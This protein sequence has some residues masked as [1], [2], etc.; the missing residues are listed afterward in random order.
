ME[1]AISITL[2]GL[3][4]NIE[5]D[6]YERLDNYL[7]SIRRYYGGE[8]SKE[9]LADIESSIAEKFNDKIK[10]KKKI[11]TKK[12]VEEV[13]K[14]MGEVEDF[15]NEGEETNKKPSSR[16]SEGQAFHIGKRLYRNPDDVVIAGVCSGIAAYFGIDPVFVRIVMFLLIFAN[17]VGVLAYFIL[18]IVMPE[19]ETNSQKLEMKGE[20][21]NVKKLEESIK[22][23]AQA[24][25]EEGQNAIN[26]IKTQKGVL[27]KIINFPIVIFRAMIVFLRKGI[28]LIWPITRIFFGVIFIITAIA[29]IFGMTVLSGVMLFNMS[30][31]Y[32]VSDL[33][34]E[35]LTSSVMY[36]VGILGIYF[37]VVVPVLFLFI[38]GFTMLRNK[39]TFRVLSSSFLLGLW[40]ISVVAGVVAAGDLTPKVMEKLEQTRELETVSHTYE[41]KDFTKL[42]LSAHMDAVVK[43]G[44]EFSITMEGREKDLDRLE[45]NIEEGQLQITQKPREEEGKFCVF[46]FDQNIKAEIILPDLESFVAIRSVKAEVDSFDSM[47]KVSV[48]E[49]AQVDLSVNGGDLEVFVAGASSRLNIMDSSDTL[50]LSME[51]YSRFYANDL[52]AENIIIDMDSLSR[53]TLKGETANLTAEVSGPAD[54]FAKDLAAQTAKVKVTSHGEAEI[55]AL[56]SLDAIAQEHGRIYYKGNPSLST[57]TAQEG[58][59][60]RLDDY[61]FNDVRIN[62]GDKKI[63]IIFGSD[64]YSPTMSSIRGIELEPSYLDESVRYIW[65]TNFGNLVD[66][67]DDPIYVQSITNDGDSIYWT[68]M[69]D[70]EA[71]LSEEPIY[72]YLRAK[73][74]DGD[75]ISES[76]LKLEEESEGVFRVVD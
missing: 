53:A 19:A 67:W 18:W 68:F 5:E 8:E 11:I 59:V 1:K 12:D 34:L 39:N 71:S 58:K 70:S 32:I 27:Y 26:R 14:V 65:S 9:I 30:S 51:G 31:P 76:E 17:G 44:E 66:S 57:K 33:P 48:G 20:P 45:F 29:S 52:D 16:S 36:Y 35:I 63:E 4:F 6:A 10:G 23:K 50:N 49:T 28:L 24:A 60:E 74:D 38:L 62:N 7:E 22:E 13:I 15:D 55:Y 75:T 2:S 25:K 64:V 61:E 56:D 42:Y 43:E 3:I 21:V 69:G 54:L 40:M 47:R 73:D 72:I 41:Y 46:C 37:A